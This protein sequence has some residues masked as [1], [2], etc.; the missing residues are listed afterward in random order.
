VKPRHNWIAMLA[1]SCVAACGSAAPKDQAPAPV[2]DPV[3]QLSNIN[4]DYP[5]VASARQALTARTDA[6]SRTEDGWLVVEVPAE[7]STWR[8]VPDNYLAAPAV[9]ERRTTVQGNVVSVETGVL[10]QGPAP[11]CDTLKQDIQSQTQQIRIVPTINVPMPVAA[12][13]S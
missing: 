10:C 11:A 5:D 3:L 1:C 12:P 6:S 9:V 8:F 2:A 7:H 4:V 13:G